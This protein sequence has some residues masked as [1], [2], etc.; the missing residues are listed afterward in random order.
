MMDAVRLI[1][2]FCVVTSICGDNKKVNAAN[3]P[4][5]ETAYATYLGG[6][7]WDQ[8]REVIPYPDGTVLIG[9]QTCSTDMP[10]SDGV[11]QHKYAGDDPNL[12]HGGVYGGD[13]YLARLSPDGER[14]VAATYLGG[15][16]Q[17]RNVYGM[18]LDR[19]GNVVITSMTRSHDLPTTKGCFQP[20]HGGGRGSVFAAKLSSDLRQL[21]W[22]TY[23]GGS[24]DE[25]PRG[26]LA[27]DGEDN[28][29]IFGTTASS[30]FPT[31]PGSH[32]TRRNGPRDAFVAKLKADGSGLVWST[33]FGGSAADY[34]LGGQ[35]P[36]R[37][38]LLDRVGLRMDA[39]RAIAR[40]AMPPLLRVSDV[41]I[42]SPTRAQHRCP[43]QHTARTNNRPRRASRPGCLPPVDRGG[44]LQR[45]LRPP[46]PPSADP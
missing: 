35:R 2:W 39:Q 29:C 27:L 23:V 32:R 7:Q 33:L 46:T 9:A 24:D 21:L 4:R 36:N 25:A 41:R 45:S 28:V 12:G 3:P 22:C 17:E 6:S 14:I 20:Q 11:V 19:D 37:R 30:D 38:E 5:Y 43:C 42:S 34:M 8:A 13:C 31:T 10:I 40:L 16:K 44:H 26:G 1:C 15:S 18:E